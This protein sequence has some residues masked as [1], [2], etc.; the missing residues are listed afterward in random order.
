MTT[1][2]NIDKKYTTCAT[3]QYALINWNSYVTF[4]SETHVTSVF[5]IPNRFCVAEEEQ[6]KGKISDSIFVHLL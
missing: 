1:K 2:D 6:R 3:I 5:I 4:I